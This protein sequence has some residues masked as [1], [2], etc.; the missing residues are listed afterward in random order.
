[1]RGVVSLEVR[2]WVTQCATVMRDRE[3]NALRASL[4]LLHAAQLVAGLILHDLVQHEPALGVVQQPKVLLSLINLDNVHEASREEHV[5]AHLAVHL[6]EP[7][8][9][10]HLSLLVVESILQAVSEQ[11]DQRHAL[12]ALVRTRR[13]PWGEHALQLVQHPVG[14]CEHALQVLL[15]SPR[16]DCLSA[17]PASSLVASSCD[18]GR[19][20]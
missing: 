2:I 1:L 20:S 12:A 16:H 6:D 9:R 17:S 7:L 10:D 13:R 11:D 18:C 3:W 19:V 4:D 14:G 15:R 8:H 5:G